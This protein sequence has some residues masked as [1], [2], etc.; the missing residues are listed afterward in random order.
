M[1]LRTNFSQKCLAAIAA[2]ILPSTTTAKPDRDVALDDAHTMRFATTEQAAKLLGAADAWVEACGQFDRQ[3]RVQ[4]EEP[5]T[6]EAFLKFATAHVLAW[7]DQEIT[8]MTGI[9]ES[10]RAKITALSLDLDLPAEILLVQT[11][12]V[13]EGNAGGYTR[14]A[15]IVIPERQLQGTPEQLES[16]MLHELFHVM[17]R[18]NPTVRI[19]IYELVGF[20]YCGEIEYPKELI[21]R[22]ITNPDAFHFDACIELTVEERSAFL[23]PLTLSTSAT[24]SGGGMFTYV[25]IEFLEVELNSGRATP[26][27]VNGQ[28]VLYEMGVVQGYMEKIGQNTGY[29]IHAEEIL[30]D[31][32][33]YAVQDKQGLPNP[34][35]PA[36]IIEIL[37]R[38]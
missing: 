27:Y 23:I 30:A 11:T 29:I 37:T 31:N 22:R 13:E 4:S 36:G 1:N 25:T 21:P 20:Q 2:I 3:V 9:V 12:G 5:V 15:A 28:P 8:K 18:H 35:I 10:M 16:F 32:F 33:T 7:D 38:K 26:K 34:E 14:A 6:Q 17:T 24:Y 19:P